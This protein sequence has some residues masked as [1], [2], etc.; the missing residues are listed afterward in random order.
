MERRGHVIAANQFE[1]LVAL[2]ATLRGEKGCPWDRE[3]THRSLRQYLLEEAYEVLEA[4]DQERYDDMKEE[5]GDLLLQVVFHAQIAAEQGRF[6]I[7]DVVQ[8]INDKLVRRHPHVFGDAQIHTA[9]EQTVHW[10]N[11]KQGEGKESVVDGVPREL[12]A[13]LRAHRVQSKAAT[14]GFDWQDASQ[15]WPKVE[16]ELAELRRACQLGD[17]KKVEEELGDVLFSLVNLS[18]FIHVNP[19]DALRGTVDKFIRRFKQVE[20][21]LKARGRSL[22]EATLQEMDEIWE[23]V[24]GDEE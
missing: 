21:E 19:E 5:L 16:E 7:A 12:S 17:Q 9:E 15:V 22:Q 2:M 23:R 8:G 10:E 13:L 6:T 20:R 11:V 1:R 18:R 3:Q 14:V 24:K 4:I